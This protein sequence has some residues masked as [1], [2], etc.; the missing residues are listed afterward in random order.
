[1]V[2]GTYL[3]HS[4]SVELPFS[5]GQPRAFVL[6]KEKSEIASC[7]AEGNT[8]KVAMT[9]AIS[10][11]CRVSVFAPDGKEVEHYAK[12]LDVKDG[13]A[14]YSIPFA[15][16]DAAGEWKA[17]ITDVVSGSTKTVTLKR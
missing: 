17:Q 4:D 1:M 5:I 10:A 9:A 2:P 6:R 16:S 12:N 15:V 7:K 11:V 3:G 14:E 13:K 8:V